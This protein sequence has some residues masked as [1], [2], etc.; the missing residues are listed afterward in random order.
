MLIVRKNQINNLIATVSMN[1]TLANPYYL[2]SF[3]HEV[4]KERV[5]FIPEVVTSNCRYDKFRFLEGSTNL[6]TTPPT[7]QFPYLGQYYYS[8][9]EQ[10]SS[11]NTNIALTY[12][13]LESGRAIVLVDDGN[14]DL[15][16]FEPYISNDEDDANYIYISDMEQ[17]CISGT[18]PTP[19]SS[20]FLTP[21]VTPTNTTTPTV[22]PTITPTNTSTP[23]TTPTITPTPSSTPPPDTPLAFG[24]L[25]WIDFTRTSSLSLNTPDDTRVSG[26]TDLIASVPFTVESGNA[27]EAPFYFPTGYLGVSGSTTQNA[28]PLVNP[29]GTYTSH[30]NGFTW[31]GF[32]DEDASGVQFG[33]SFVEG[34]DG[35]S[36][37]TGTR[38]FFIRDLNQPPNRFYTNVRLNSGGNLQV[39][40]DLSTTGYTSLAVRAYRQSGDVFLE[41]WDN[42]TLIAS[43]TQPNDSLYTLTDH[44]YRLMFDGGLDGNTEQFYFDRKLSDSQLSQMFTYLA[45]KY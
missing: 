36:F 23:T 3:Q 18:T 34:Y 28:S 38:F 39:G 11:T 25:W 41:V 35:S 40:F 8:I 24:A 45:N 21:S 27:N 33:G 30:H 1:K 10:I 32:V 13:K 9:Y 42:N 22:T 37:P 12:N 44:Q 20:P 26:A 31:F 19:T 4:S 5:S 14:P 43:A 15:C 6:S 2:F 29:L 17:V 7:V 16:F